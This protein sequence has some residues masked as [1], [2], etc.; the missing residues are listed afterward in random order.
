MASTFCQQCG[1]IIEDE[2]F[3]CPHCGTAVI[4]QY[5]G[6]QLRMLNQEE[7]AKL[8]APTAMGCGLGLLVGLVFVILIIVLSAAPFD[9]ADLS[10]RRL[11]GIP[12]VTSVVGGAFGAMAA[13]LLA[14]R[15]REQMRKK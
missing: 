8:L 7:E 9:P 5:T 3:L 1:K 15:K 13:Y 12:L 10:N 4:P 14:K 2:G 6:A 11:P